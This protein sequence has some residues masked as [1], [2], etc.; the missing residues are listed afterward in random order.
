[1]LLILLKNGAFFTSFFSGSFWEWKGVLTRNLGFFLDLMTLLTAV[2][3]Y[4]YVW[5]LRGVAFHFVDVVL[6]LIIRVNVSINTFV[7]LCLSL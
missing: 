1:M 5:W 3:H 4:L 6:S 2:G 7:Q